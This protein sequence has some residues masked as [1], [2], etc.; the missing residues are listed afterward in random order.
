MQEPEFVYVFSTEYLPVKLGPPQSVNLNI[1]LDSRLKEPNVNF[2]S[3]NKYLYYF[4]S[5]S[6]SA[7]NS[8]F[9]KEGGGFET[10]SSAKV[11]RELSNA[12]LANMQPHENSL[13]I[14]R[15]VCWR[16][17]CSFM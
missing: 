15:V 4:I 3:L 13:L 9:L 7:L 10:G 8:S 12:V 14:T 6:F 5:L 16:A 17:S 11:I 1:F 2:L